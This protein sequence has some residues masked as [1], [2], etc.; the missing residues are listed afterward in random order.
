MS[1]RL[2]SLLQKLLVPEAA[3]AVSGGSPSSASVARERLAIVLAQQRG[4]GLRGVNLL[5]MQKDILGVVGKYMK[6]DL[7]DVTV[8]VRKLDNR[9]EIMEVQVAIGNQPIFQA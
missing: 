9:L 3:S 7:N 4:D 6:V 2:R 8:G 5:D 1:L